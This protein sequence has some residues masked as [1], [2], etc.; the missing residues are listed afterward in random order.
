MAT[1][2]SQLTLVPLADPAADPFADR[3]DNYCVVVTPRSDLRKCVK[4]LPGW[5]DGAAE[6]EYLVPHRALCYTFGGLG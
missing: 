6:G 5:Q 3:G 4:L 2:E 1:I